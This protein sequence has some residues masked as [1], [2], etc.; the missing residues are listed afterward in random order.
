VG[1]SKVLITR[2]LVLADVVESLIGTAYLHGGFEL[3]YECMK[4]FDL[5]IRWEPLS[6]RI[7]QIQKRYGPMEELPAQVTTAEKIIGYTF[8]R[9]RFLVEALTHSS[10]Q[11]DF[12]HSTGTVSYERMEFIGDS[13]LDMIIAD[14][15]YHAPGKKYTP[16]HI[17]LRKAAMVNANFLAYICLSSYT[18]VNSSMPQPDY[19]GHIIL[20]S[21]TDRIALWQCLLHSSPQVLEDCRTTPTRFE[22]VAAEI[23]EALRENPGFPW[24]ALTRIQAPKWFSDM[25]ESIIG[26]VYFDSGGSMDACR[27]LL[28]HL[29]IFGILERIVRDDVE[30]LHPVSLLSMYSRQAEKKVKLV[31]SEEKG[32]VSCYLIDYEIVDDKEVDGDEVPGTRCTVESHSKASREMARLTAAEKAIEVLHLRTGY[33]TNVKGGIVRQKKRQRV[34][35]KKAA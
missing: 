19:E 1:A 21:R 2:F 35:V 30:V 28:R 13:I 23:E 9:K 24:A 11:P 14:Y 4:F 10:F 3:G 27:D 31:F 26:A 33:K 8:Q 18:E 16:G 34:R 17:F 7:E 29:G 12:E 32:N 20:E 25:I 22:G 15:L 5:G 6:T